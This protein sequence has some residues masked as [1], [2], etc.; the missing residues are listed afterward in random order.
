MAGPNY[1]RTPAHSGCGTCGGPERRTVTRAWVGPHI[2]AARRAPTRPGICSVRSN[3]RRSRR[4]RP[5]PRC[6]S[7]CSRRR[8]PDMRT[9]SKRS[10]RIPRLP[11]NSVYC[12][13]ST[14]AETLTR[15]RSSAVDDWE[16]L[17]LLNPMR[18]NRGHS[19]LAPARRCGAALERTL[20]ESI[21]SRDPPRTP[22]Q[23]DVYRQRSATT[24]QIRTPL[25]SRIRRTHT[26]HLAH[27]SR[28]HGTPR[29]KKTRPCPKTTLDSDPLAAA[30][31]SPSGTLWGG[32]Q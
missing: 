12:R 29:K 2:A 25:H 13:S 19:S 9:V 15:L 23:T 3:A 11:G 27:A 21:L 24:G 14:T 7:G 5:T 6:S 30:S 18:L 1:W 4:R 16:H 28:R 10:I 8:E 26:T 31:V 22:P 32:V 17:P 20:R